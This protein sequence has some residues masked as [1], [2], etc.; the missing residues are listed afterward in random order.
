MI[1]LC[2][3]VLMASTVGPTMPG[4]GLMRRMGHRST[5]VGS[6]VVGQCT[7]GVFGSGVT[8]WGVK[9][10]GDSFITTTFADASGAQ[11]R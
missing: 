11:Y 2:Q 7:G 1:S 8:L 6:S 10:V 9:N 3:W 5:G 4:N